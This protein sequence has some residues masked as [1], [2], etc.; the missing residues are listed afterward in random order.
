MEFR[1]TCSFV[2]YT[3]FQKTLP[4]F[5]SSSQS[6]LKLLNMGSNPVTVILPDNE[7]VVL[8]PNQVCPHSHTKQK[9]GLKRL[10]LSEE[11]SVN[12]RIYLPQCLHSFNSFFVSQFSD[13]FFTF[14]AGNVNI[15]IGSP[16][17]TKTFSL[18]KGQRKTLLIPS[19][20]TDEW[21][22]VSQKHRI[23]KIKTH[24]RPFHF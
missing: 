15:S 21:L 14:E 11:Q 3:T 12:V 24:K 9:L 17:V 1:N 22:L 5:P 19:T 20:I 8:S 7:P 10:I 18:D 2:L 23:M 4:T 16:A 6:Q 13:D